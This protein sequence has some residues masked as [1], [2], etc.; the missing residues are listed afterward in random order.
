MDL[1]LSSHR[2]RQIK[3][4][5]ST[6]IQDL[7][8]TYLSQTHLN[9]RL[10]EL[11]QQFEHPQPRQ[12]AKI[13]WQSIN[14]DLIIGI[15]PQLFLAILKGSIDTEA[16]IGDY[17][18]TSRQYLDPIHPLMAEFV[19]GTVD[20]MG[21]LKSKGIWELE[22]RCHAPVLLAIYYRLSGEK[23]KPNPKKARLYQPSNSP[24]DDLYRHGLHRISTEY[25]ATCLYLWLMG[26]S[27]GILRQILGE[28]VRDE[29]NH[30]IKFWGFG[31]WLYPYPKG[32]RFIHGCRQL[33]PRQ[34]AGSNLFK[35]Y[36][37]MMSVLHWHEWTLSH[38]LQLVSTLYLVMK[39]LLAWHHSLTSADLEQI[40]GLSPDRLIHNK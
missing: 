14:K 37:R 36:H 16:P 1:L 7:I 34:S 26:H 3:S 18:H 31:I 30:L 35:T 11:P 9:D 2:D 5:F 17:T 13:D 22:E 12:W 6:T 28:L 21:N 19:G 4:D 33:L 8:N 20:E 38:R 39:Q 40:F 29:V 10:Q 32:S 25:G 24:D 27:T 15:E 23:I